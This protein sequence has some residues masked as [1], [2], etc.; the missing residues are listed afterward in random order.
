[1]PSV[2]KNS[3]VLVIEH[4]NHIARLLRF[5]FERHGCNVETIDDGRAALAYL[6]GPAVAPDLILLEIML[7]YVDGFQIVRQIR[8]QAGWVDTG[9]IMVT[10]KNTEA[11][12]VAAFAAGADDFVA[13]PFMPAELVARS[14]RLLARSPRTVADQQQPL[15]I[16]SGSG[17]VV[18]AAAGEPLRSDVASNAGAYS[19]SSVHLGQ[20]VVTIMNGREKEIHEVQHGLRP[21]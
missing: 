10:S 13:K 21:K 8:R 17:I 12:C 4:D 9:L 20:P 7:P 18:I 11:D 16:G 5:L 19:P 1:M 15:L 6:S 14:A 3:S 2:L